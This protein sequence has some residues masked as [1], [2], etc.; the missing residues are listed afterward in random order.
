[1]TLSP[2]LIALIKDVT[3]ATDEEIESWMREIFSLN[4]DFGKKERWCLSLIARIVAERKVALDGQY[5]ISKIQSRHDYQARQ[6]EFWRDGA[7]KEADRADRAEA[8]L[9]ALEERGS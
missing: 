5:Q 4:S 6:V 9:S 2:E 8:A 1:M 3:P 7:R